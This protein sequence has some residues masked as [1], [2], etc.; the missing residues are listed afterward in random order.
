MQTIHANQNP[1]AVRA[2]IAQA[3][4][5]ADINNQSRALWDAI[6]EI[7]GESEEIWCDGL[8]GV[9][10]VTGDDGVTRAV[11]LR[12]FCFCADDAAAGDDFVMVFDPAEAAKISARQIFELGRG[13]LN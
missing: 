10:S 8:A 4:C 11:A 7:S 13:A 1:A 6:A 2:A 12:D 5:R 9:F 3:L